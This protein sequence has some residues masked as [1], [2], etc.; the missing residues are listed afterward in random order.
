MLSE[1]RPKDQT[2]PFLPCQLTK[3]LQLDTAGSNNATAL[4]C[5]NAKELK[6]FESDFLAFPSLEKNNYLCWGGMGWG[7]KGI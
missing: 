4:G 3:L 6:N 1:H 2:V 5:E 7:R